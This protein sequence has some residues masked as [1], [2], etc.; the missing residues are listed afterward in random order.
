MA[1]V[2]A[3]VLH[4]FPGAISRSRST[5]PICPSPDCLPW[6]CRDGAAGSSGSLDWK[7]DCLG[8]WS[9]LFGP[10]LWRR[11]ALVSGDHPLVTP[12]CVS[13]GRDPAPL[14]GTLRLPR[15][16]PDKQR[17]KLIIISINAEK[18]FT[19]IQHHF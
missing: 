2:G 9:S 17:E 18:G 13:V 6:G 5:E 14:Y 16:N 12:S 8:Q 19:K 10:G 15:Q 3:P 1:G 7:E 11:A 4:S